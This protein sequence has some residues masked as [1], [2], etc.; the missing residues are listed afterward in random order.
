[1]DCRQC[2]G[3]WRVFYYTGDRQLAYFPAA[4]TDADE[5]DAFVVLSRGRALARIED[6]LRLAGLVRE[7]KE[8]GVKE[9]RPNV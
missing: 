5:A 3:Q 7:L 8:G 2:W 1:V 4:W 6:L 9:N